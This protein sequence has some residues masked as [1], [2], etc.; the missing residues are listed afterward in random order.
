MRQCTLLIVL[1]STLMR[2][3]F[4]SDGLISRRRAGGAA[5]PE[6]CR[7]LR[8][9]APPLPSCQTPPR[10]HAKPA[11]LLATSPT[12][13]AVAGAPAAPQPGT[14][15]APPQTPGDAANPS[16]ICAFAAVPRRRSPAPQTARPRAVGLISSWYTLG[17][18][19]TPS[20]NF[21]NISSAEPIFYL[22]ISICD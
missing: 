18:F 22:S 2:R 19:F 12:A 8:P 14:V 7:P 15:P 20:L 5:S 13:L 21:G 1:Q 9:R 3:Q 17:D 4:D 16:A 6:P 10:G 11:R